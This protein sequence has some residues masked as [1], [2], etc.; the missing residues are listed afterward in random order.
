MKAANRVVFNTGV[1]YVQLI[2][3]MV[4]GLYTTR[5]VLNALGETDYGIYML[6]AGMVGML[7][8]LNSNM[9]TTSM[10][11]MAHSLGS[12]DKVKTLK[13]FNTT[14][15]L[16]FII[17]VIVIVVMEAGGW[18]MFEY[19]LNIPEAKVF[20]AKIVFHFMVITTFIAVISVP[21]DAVMNSHENILA[22]SVVDTLGYILKLGL[23]IYLIYSNGN[24][25]IEYGFFMLIIQ[26]LLRIIK[27]WYSK[28]KYDE[29]KIRFREYVDKQEMKSILSFTGWNLFGSI[30]SISVRQ[31]KGI[32]L[33]MFFGVKLNAAD[34]IS[35]TASSHLNMISASMTRSLNPQLIKSEGSGNRDRMLRITEIGSKFSSFLFAL[36]AVPV[37][38]EASYL[39]ELWLKNVPDFAVIFFQL[40]LIG[41]LIEKFTFQITHAIRAVGKIK[42]F[43][44]TETMIALLSIPLAY[45]AFRMGY[46]PDAIYVIGIGTALVAMVMRLYFGKKIADL[47]ISSYIRNAMFSVILPMIPALAVSI[48]VIHFAEPGFIRLVLVTVLYITIFSV[49]FWWKGLNSDEKQRLKEIAISFL[50]KIKIKK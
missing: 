28:V 20:D 32:L 25:L 26:V 43:Q 40:S 14:L 47:K 38:I 34:G 15:Y 24:L 50:R 10:R 39:L 27:Q 12:G 16:H 5:I 37:T 46:P 36:F 48:G 13:T 42:A 7:N 33:N 1:L 31:L 2:M 41:M 17:G 23:A 19:L 35:K 4:I 18:L 11:F 49:L 21:Y 3:A 9:S 29:C 22:L 30:A 8:V 45:V 6:V 44:V